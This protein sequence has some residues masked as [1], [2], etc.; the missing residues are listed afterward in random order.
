MIHSCLG[1]DGSGDH[2]SLHRASPP[3]T[4]DLSTRQ[5]VRPNRETFVIFQT[6]PFRVV[7]NAVR[8]TKSS[9]V[10]R[11][12]SS[13]RTENDPLGLTTSSL[14]LSGSAGLPGGTSPGESPCESAKIAPPG[15]DSTST[16]RLKPDATR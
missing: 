2:A 14:P 3:R 7:M 8:P 16:S 13:T 15:P 4:G 1:G 12:S 9:E 5:C 6:S 10:G 11:S